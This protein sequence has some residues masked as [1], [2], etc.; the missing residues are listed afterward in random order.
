MGVVTKEV[1]LFVTVPNAGVEAAPGVLNGGGQCD[2]FSDLFHSPVGV[3]GLFNTLK[4]S[5]FVADLVCISEDCPLE[6]LL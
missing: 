5:A 4:L 2:A 1:L 6:K 3:L